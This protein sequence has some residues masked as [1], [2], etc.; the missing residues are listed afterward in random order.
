MR[1]WGV[2]GGGVQVDSYTDEEVFNMIN[3]FHAGTTAS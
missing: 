2:G 3:N 1:P